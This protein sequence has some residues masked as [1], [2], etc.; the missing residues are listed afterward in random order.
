MFD[1]WPGIAG[2]GCILWARSS[3][4]FQHC[5]QTILTNSIYII[6]KIYKIRKLEKFFWKS[7]RK[8]FKP[9]KNNFSFPTWI[10]QKQLNEILYCK[11]ISIFGNQ[12]RV[13]CVCAILLYL[14]L[15]GSSS[16]KLFE[17]DVWWNI[18]F[19]NNL[20]K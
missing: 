11:G 19:I 18:N 1:L 15:W 17:I 9:S 8:I 4:K 3:S 16:T 2:N 12:D 6:F 13:F 5:I 10:P 14:W 20:V 7:G